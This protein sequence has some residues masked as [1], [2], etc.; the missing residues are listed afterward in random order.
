MQSVL[1]SL[2]WFIYT[3]F[4]DSVGIMPMRFKK[5]IAHYY[6]DA[7]IRKLYFKALGVEMGEGT[8][9]N[10]GL[11]AIV[12]SDGGIHVRI[13]D[14]VSIGPNLTVIT[15]SSANNGVEIN[16]LPYVA[17]VLTQNA[18]ILVEDEVWIGANVVLL[19]GVTVGRCSVIG[20]GAVVTQDVAPY[21]V[22]AGVPAKK[23]RSLKQESTHE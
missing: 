10:L 23:I 12:P 1:E 8:Y 2:D 13:G 17:E 5:L 14:R 11:K 15:E 3:L 18:P 22:V 7:R 20:A 16:S 6:T 4:E 9:A 21:T 19:P